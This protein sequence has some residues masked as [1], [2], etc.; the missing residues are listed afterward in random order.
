MFTKGG[1]YLDT[2]FGEEIKQNE[3]LKKQVKVIFQFWSRQRYGVNHRIDEKTKIYQTVYE[4]IKNLT[5]GLPMVK[6]SKGLIHKKYYDYLKSVLKDS[7]NSEKEISLFT[8]RVWKTREILLVLQRI[9]KDLSRPVNLNELFWMP[10]F[11]NEFNTNG[12]SYF[13]LYA[14]NENSKDEY[15]K[16]VTQ[17]YSFPYSS[18]VS[19]MQKQK[20]AILLRNF[21]LDKFASLS[22]L[23]ELVS[24]YKEGQEELYVKKANTIY[25]FLEVYPQIARFKANLLKGKSSSNK[26]SFKS[27]G[28]KKRLQNIKEFKL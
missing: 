28:M 21:V 5:T 16:L 23:Q 26:N 2:L 12:F 17:F 10:I 19:S 6:T 3:F 4:Y 14:L 9:P 22:E 27:E 24:W 13:S 25:R 7:S 1:N 15:N 8:H 20:E 18:H 11:I